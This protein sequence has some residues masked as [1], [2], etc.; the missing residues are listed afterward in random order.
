MQLTQQL[1]YYSTKSAKRMIYIKVLMKILRPKKEET[2]R[3]YM[4][5]LKF[6]TDV[7][8]MAQRSI[9]TLD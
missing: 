4:F 3:K 7:K 8:I 5:S 1:S 6:M 9:K 2:F